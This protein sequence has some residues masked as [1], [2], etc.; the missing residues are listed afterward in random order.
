M[1]LLTVI[2]LTK[3]SILLSFFSDTTYIRKHTNAISYVAL[4]RVSHFKRTG[5]INQELTLLLLQ[6]DGTIWRQPV[7]TS[8]V[9]SLSQTLVASL[10]SFNVITNN[11]IDSYSWLYSKQQIIHKI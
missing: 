5:T 10:N 7:M 2:R 6:R 8:C 1:L 9:P 11:V 3:V 4:F